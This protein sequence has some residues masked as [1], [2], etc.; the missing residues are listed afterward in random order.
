M[1]LTARDVTPHTAEVT[2]KERIF[3]RISAIDTPDFIDN[4]EFI[5]HQYAPRSS[6]SLFLSTQVCLMFFPK[7]AVRKV[8]YGEPCAYERHHKDSGEDD[9]EVKYF[10][11]YRVGVD[12][13]TAVAIAKSYPSKCLLPQTEQNTQHDAYQSAYQRD[14]ACLD[15]KY[16]A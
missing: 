10:D 5:A 12:E 13:E 6:H 7:Q 4:M 16:L 2:A 11:A 15:E 3:L 9:D 14:E 8:T 1:P